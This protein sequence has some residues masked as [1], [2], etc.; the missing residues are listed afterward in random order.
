MSRKGSSLKLFF[1]PF[2]FCAKLSHF[3]LYILEL[4]QA[5]DTCRRKGLM[6]LYSSFVEKISGMLSHWLAVVFAGPQDG[7]PEVGRW[8]GG[9]AVATAS[10]VSWG[11]GVFASLCFCVRSAEP[12]SLHAFSPHPLITFLHLYHDNLYRKRSSVVSISSPT[13]CF[14]KSWIDWLRHLVGIEKI[15][16]SMENIYWFISFILC[17]FLAPNNLKTLNME[18]AFI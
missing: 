12:E 15:F 14:G 3:R 2:L 5:V 1:W 4:R 13:F 18:S 16:S 17:T 8:A 6:L 10:I 11:A 9:C 7:G